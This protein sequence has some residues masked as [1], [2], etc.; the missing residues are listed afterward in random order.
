MDKD[1]YGFSCKYFGE[2]CDGWEDE[3]DEE[4]DGYISIYSQ[5]RAQAKP[6]KEHSRRMAQL[7]NHALTKRQ[8][9]LSWA[10]EKLSFK[11]LLIL[12][13]LLQFIN[14]KLVNEEEG[15]IG[16]PL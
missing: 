9:D 11:P 3:E 2:Y 12:K 6:K 14:L 8:W 16:C 5:T 4:D 15:V 10:E 13:I 7:K 1:Y